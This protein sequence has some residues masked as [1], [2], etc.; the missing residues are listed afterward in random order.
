MIEQKAFQSL[1]QTY[2]QTMQ[3]MLGA[4]PCGVKRQGQTP[5]KTYFGS[6]GK[7]P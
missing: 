7:L 2:L 4:S 1:G 5:A 6:Y 3:R